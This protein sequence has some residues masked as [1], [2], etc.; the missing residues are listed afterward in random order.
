MMEND[1]IKQ[2]RD[3]IRQWWQTESRPIT[4]YELGSQ[5]GINRRGKKIAD[6]LIDVGLPLNGLVV[7]RDTG[8]PSTGWEG[9]ARAE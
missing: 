3:L 8:V 9:M 5:L 7:L 6:L 4:Y 2:A 1:Q